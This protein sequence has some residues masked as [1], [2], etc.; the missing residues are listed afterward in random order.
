MASDPPHSHSHSH[1]HH[2]H[3]HD[4]G[5][6]HSHVHH[7]HAPGQPHAPQPIGASLLRLSMPARLGVAAVAVAVL[8]AGILV[9][10]R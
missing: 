8:W 10:M 9:A 1:D 3:D 6:D 5:H 4:H 7:H 2:D